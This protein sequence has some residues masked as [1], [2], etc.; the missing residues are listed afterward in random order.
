LRRKVKNIT[1]DSRTVKKDD[2]FFAIKGE[3]F[4]GH[5]FIENSYSAGA[6]AAVSSK[7]LKTDKPYILVKDTT[8]FLGDLARYYKKK[9][10]KLIAIAVTGSC[11]KTTTKDM[12]YTVLKTKYNVVTNIGSFNNHIGVPLTIFKLDN[13]SQILLSEVGMNHFGELDYLGSIVQPDIACITNVEP[14]HLEGLKTLENIAKAKFE[15]IEHLPMNGVA[16]INGDNEYILKESKNYPVE[17]IK[18]GF[19]KNVDF[20][21]KEVSNKNSFYTAR[22]KNQK[23]SLPIPGF[24]NVYNLLIT[25]ALAECF[26]I[27]AQTIKKAIESFE[28]TGRRMKIVEHKGLKIIDDCYNANPTATANALKI[29]SDLEVKGRRIFV[30]GDMKELG[31]DAKKYHEYIGAEALKN[32]VTETICVGE[33]AAITA[34]YIKKNKGKSQSFDDINLALE[35]LLKILKAGDALL[36]KASHSMNFEKISE[37]ILKRYV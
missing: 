32:N 16:F 11:G 22:Y 4:D 7:E 17:F 19:S 36:I 26:K 37:G 30:F 18:Y 3:T 31:K 6:F 13:K 24:H 34:K 5:S 12:I 14:V 35:Y 10:D 2:L 1:T 29:L 15:I 23:I 9:F 28:P 33:L 21:F 25:C 8:L 20:T 27:N